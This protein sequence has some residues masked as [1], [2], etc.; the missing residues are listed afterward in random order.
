MAEQ[1][2]AL[3]ASSSRARSFGRRR[4]AKILGFSLAEW[5][6]MLFLLGVV[7]A[8]VLP[9]WWITISSFKTARELFGSVPQPWPSSLNFANYRY[10]LSFP[11]IDYLGMFANSV[12]LTTLTVLFN[13]ALVTMAG[14]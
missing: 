7:V 4:P 14:Y 5:S 13:V 8:C 12:Y 3:A 9:L 11:S 10:L 1:G 6:M 2:S